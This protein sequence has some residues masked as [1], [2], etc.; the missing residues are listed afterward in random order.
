M[1]K[2]P[3]FEL[4]NRLDEFASVIRDASWT[5]GEGSGSIDAKKGVSDVLEMIRHVAGNNG[6]I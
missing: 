3:G 6:R 2:S 4:T 1:Q 5:T